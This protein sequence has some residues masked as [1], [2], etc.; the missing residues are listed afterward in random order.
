MKFSNNNNK[1][2]QSFSSYDNRKI[3]NNIYDK[4]I[5]IIDQ[6]NNINQ[7]QDIC[8]NIDNKFDNKT[9]LTSLEKKE[10]NLLRYNS[11]SPE[12]QEKINKKKEKKIEKMNKKKILTQLNHSKLLSTLA[13]SSVNIHSSVPSLNQYNVKKKLLVFDFNKVLV[14]RRKGKQQYVIRPNLFN[15]LLECNKNFHIS[16][17]SSMKKKNIKLFC[18]DFLLQS[19]NKIKKLNEINQTNYSDISFYFQFYQ[20]DCDP[21]IPPQIQELIQKYEETGEYNRQI[22]NY[23]PIFLKNLSKV[24]YRFPQF[25]ETNTVSLILTLYLLLII[26]NS[27]LLFF[28]LLFRY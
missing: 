25:N 2:Q 1:T 20:H 4:N 12:E 19:N 22:D 7:E 15:F 27:F 6:D 21:L 24:Y 14:S 8:P 28:Y 18:N 16:I 3:N 10:L 11:L 13:T 26:P 5:N 23:K 9:N 17:W